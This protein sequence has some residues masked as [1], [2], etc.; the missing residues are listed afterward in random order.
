[1]Q[2]ADPRIERI[3]GELHEV[4]GLLDKEG[5]GSIDPQD[6]RA[7]MRALGFGADNTTVYQLLS[8]VDSNGSQALDFE[9]LSHLMLDQLKVHGKGFASRE[10]A[11]EVFECIDAVDTCQR[12]GYVDFAHLRRMADI[13]G[14]S[15]SDAELEVMIKGA[16]SQCEDRVTCED[17]YQMI[18]GGDAA[19]PDDAPHFASECSLTGREM[20]RTYSNK[21]A[22]TNL[23]KVRTKV[24]VMTA[25][26]AA[27][28]KAP[29][30]S[31]R[32][33]SREVN[34]S[35]TVA[36]DVA[37]R[38]S[39]SGRSREGNAS[40][41]ASTDLGASPSRAGR[42]RDANASPSF[43]ASSRDRCGSP[44]QQVRSRDVQADQADQPS[45]AGEAAPLAPP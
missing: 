3:M 26:R 40:P 18:M 1:M 31:A 4:F 37:A 5:R 8:D 15:I 45:P 6:V 10:T 25:M 12:T 43:G 28:R 7:H 22:K 42:S 14:D 9:A 24:F 44:S 17:F 23:A 35:P 11:N 32:P 19:L 38:P 30:A 21:L 34:T 39:Q 29:R 36:K 13:L 20:G 33:A 27:S 2:A 41:T 16:S